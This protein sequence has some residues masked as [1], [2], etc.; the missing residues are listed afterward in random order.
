MR[1]YIVFRADGTPKRT[2]CGGALAVYAGKSVASRNARC[3]GD[4][5]IE[6]EIDPTVTP[7]Y[8]KGRKV[9]PNGTP[10]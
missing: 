4:Y 1:V 5:V 9:D 2:R 8:I 10:E 7:L 3:N 6:A